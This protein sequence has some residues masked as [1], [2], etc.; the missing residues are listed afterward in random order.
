M[1]ASS[2]ISVGPQPLLFVEPVLL[3]ATYNIDGTPNVMTVSWGGVCNGDPPCVGL[4]IRSSRWSIDALQTRKSFTVNIPSASLAQQADYVGI[5]SGKTTD[6]FSKAGFTAVMS[7]IV[8][9]PYIAECPMVLECSLRQTMDLGSHT[10]LVGQIENIKV[11]A[12]CLDST[13]KAIDITQVQPLVYDG[14]KN[15]YFGLGQ[16]IGDAFSMGKALKSDA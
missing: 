6:K 15:R 16:E 10:F 5:V 13:G 12:N 3:V 14:G 4:A 2:K 7:D 9:A 11:D 1:D 8:D